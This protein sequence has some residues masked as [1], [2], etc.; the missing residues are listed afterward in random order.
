MGAWDGDSFTS[1]NE[2]LYFLLL[3]MRDLISFMW[4]FLPFEH[5][6]FLYEKSFYYIGFVQLEIN[7]YYT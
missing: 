3:S 4:V 2:V 1:H 5:S 6:L 7:E